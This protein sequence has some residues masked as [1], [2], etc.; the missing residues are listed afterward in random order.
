VTT[1][2]ATVTRWQPGT[3]VQLPPF[4]MSA[5]GRRIYE[6]LGPYAADDEGGGWVLAGLVDGIARGLLGQLEE[7]VA[8]DDSAGPLEWLLDPEH[9]PA[10]ALAWLGQ[11]VGV[12]VDPAVQEPGADPADVAEVRRLIRDA[13]MW[14]RGT[15][16]YLQAVT[17]PLLVDGAR[18]RVRERF[19]PDHANVD[20][21]HHLQVSLRWD[22]L[23]PRWKVGTA[24][25]PETYD[26][27]PEARRRILAAVPAGIKGHLRVSDVRS[28]QDVDDDYATWGAVN[29][30][31]VNWADVL[32]P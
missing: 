13:P 15:L 11:L 20:S 24:G 19:D 29:D 18:I 10:W 14:A 1:A 30:G 23:L 16:R 3:D 2:T 17:V 22:D 4:E 5:A 26:I 27:D 25:A 12:R 9:A 8:P 28:W 32:T 6:Q 31:N 7:L 21:P